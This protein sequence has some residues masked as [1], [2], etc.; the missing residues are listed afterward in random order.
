MN[1]LQKILLVTA[2]AVFL[3]A[4]ANAI[5]YFAR[6]YDP[7]LQRWLTRDPI[8]EV[9]YLSEM[10]KKLGWHEELEANLFTFVR[11]APTDKIDPL[12]LTE[13]GP[14]G[15]KCCNNSGATQWWIDDGVWKSLPS[16]KCT[17]FWDDCDGMTCGGGFYYVENLEGGSCD[18]PGKDDPTFCKRRW[19]PTHQGPNARPPGP[20]YPG[21]P[22]K[23]RG[24]PVGNPSPPNYPW[25]N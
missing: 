2:S 9:G 22:G 11:N 13:W 12:G 23:H 25:G 20:P 7:N 18:T 16:G 15:G 14:L 5:M 10:N 19:T 1:G 4:Q 8:H 17:G 24:G 3:T 6:P 21:Y